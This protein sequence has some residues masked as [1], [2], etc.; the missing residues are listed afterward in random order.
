MK[1]KNLDAYLQASAKSKSNQQN[2][3]P[4]EIVEASNIDIREVTLKISK[5]A[6]MLEPERKRLFDIFNIFK[7]AIIDCEPLSNPHENLIALKKFFGSVRKHHKRGDE[8]GIVPIVDLNSPTD[9]SNT[10][11]EH[12]MHTDAPF[13]IDPPK[14]IALQCEIPAK[15]GGISKVVCGKSVYK[16]LMEYYPKELQFLFTS[17]S[18]TIKKEKDN[19]TYQYA[20]FTEKED[21]ISIRFR[22]DKSV[23]IE[24][25]PE[26]EKVVNVFQNYVNNPK[27]QIMFKLH[28]NQILLLDNTSVLHGRTSFPKHDVRKLNKLWFEGD[29][30][31]AR[32]IQFGF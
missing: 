28:A 25:I 24:I 31:Y 8:N 18:V 6:E 16:Y 15:N 23:S 26:I 4:Q 12:P 21:K 17:G 32:E 27:N 1:N 3:A 20:I 7:F 13:Y 9:L 10:N 30:E 2:L 22:S 19:L 14:I 11:Q 5:V 29:S